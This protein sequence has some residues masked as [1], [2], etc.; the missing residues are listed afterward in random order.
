MSSEVCLEDV[1]RTGVNLEGTEEDG[2]I[3]FHFSQGGGTFLK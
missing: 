2:T 1:E 3:M